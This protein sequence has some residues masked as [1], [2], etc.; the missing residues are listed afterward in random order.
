M[1]VCMYVCTYNH[2]VCMCVICKY[3][4]IYIYMYICTIC[5]YRY[6]IYSGYKLGLYKVLPHCNCPRTH[7]NGTGWLVL[8]P[9]D[10][11]P[12]TAVGRG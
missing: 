9:E 2:T 10:E 4:C 8:K 1:Y 6:A 11:E 7:V 3:M 5:K 12:K